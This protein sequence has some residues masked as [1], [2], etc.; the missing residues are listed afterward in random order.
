M[1]KYY[2]YIYFAICLTGLLGCASRNDEEIMVEEP[3]KDFCSAPLNL[4]V[5]SIANTISWDKSNTGVAASYYQLQYGLQGFSL[6][7]GTIVDL[8]STN[9]NG[10]VMKKGNKYDIYVRTYCNNIVGWSNWSPAYTYLC[11]YSSNICEAPT[12]A[13]WIVQSQTLLKYNATFNWDNDGVSVYEIA[14]TYSNTTLPSQSDIRSISSGYNATYLDL[15]K[16][17][18]YYFYVRKVCSN[19]DRT[20]FYGPYKVKY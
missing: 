8:N 1:H 18:T 14:L 13:N 16:S 10:A 11:T 7:T 12:S 17:E 4:K 5:S 15:A 9:Y 20:S 2:I 3:I 19:G 6:G